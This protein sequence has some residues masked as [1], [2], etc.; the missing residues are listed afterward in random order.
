MSYLKSKPTVFVVGKEY[1]IVISL[2]ENGICSLLVGGETYYEENTGVLSSE[3]NYAKIRVPQKA[4]DKTKEYTV[5]YRKTI[6]RK[7]YFSEL[8]EA[9]F[10]RFEFKPIEKT[11]NINIYHAADVHYIF[12]VAKNTI[13]YFGEDT[14]LIILNGDIGEVETEENYFDILNFTGEIS[15]GK[16]PVVFARGNHDTRGRLA[17]RYTDFFPAN[18][19]DT[20]Y[21]FEIGNMRGIVLD[22]GEDKPD[23][24]DS[25]GGDEY[26]GVNIFEIYRRRELKFLKSLEADKE[27]LTFAISHMCPAQIHDVPGSK[28]DIERELYSE[29]NRELARI[30]IKFMI[31][32]HIHRTYVLKKNDERSLLPHEYNVIIGSAWS[33]NDGKY[34]IA[35]TA[36][37]IKK[38]EINFKFTDSHHNVIEEYVLDNNTEIIEKVK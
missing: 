19:K 34:E 37:N 8:G 36:I 14:D 20:Y 11:E 2:K 26:G 24:C 13:S 38:N 3:K 6:N 30:G 10:E 16:I 5:K 17:E 29:Y 31:N 9:E 21:T 28:F 15:G 27:K 7:A 35:G 22:C 1:E 12:D 18:G 32:G 23:A 33:K 4:L 25:Y